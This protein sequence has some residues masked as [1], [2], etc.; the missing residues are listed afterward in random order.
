MAQFFQKWR[1]RILIHSFR[2]CNCFPRNSTVPCFSRFR[3]LKMKDIPED[4]HKRVASISRTVWRKIMYHQIS[5]V[6]VC[7]ARCGKVV[8]LVCLYSLA[9]F[10]CKL[11]ESCFIGCQ[12]PSK[13]RSGIL[14]E[15]SCCRGQTHRLHT[16][17]KFQYLAHLIPV[18]QQ[19][20]GGL[21]FFHFT[22]H[23]LHQ[24]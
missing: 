6:I 13:V 18:F 7:C 14:C 20:Q 9:I 12:M 2:T 17:F 11:Q 5:N 4:L 16:Y 15:G 24:T 23:K 8:K 21:A 1:Q 19:P 10:I 3:G 22:V